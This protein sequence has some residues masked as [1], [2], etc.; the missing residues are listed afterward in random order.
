MEVLHFMTL[1]KSGTARRPLQLR[2]LLPPSLLMHGLRMRTTPTSQAHH[3]SPS[4]TTLDLEHGLESRSA[5][6]RVPR[7]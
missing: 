6:E 2:F 5:L 7:R 3:S 4:S 1:S